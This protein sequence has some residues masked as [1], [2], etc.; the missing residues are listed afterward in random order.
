MTVLDMLLRRL[1]MLV[2][3]TRMVRARY[4]GKVRVLQVSSREGAAQD[5][6]EHLEPAGF[7]SH[8]LAGAEAVV[9][10]LGGNSSRAVVILVND[11]SHRVVL[12]EGESAIYNM[13]HGD[14]VKV[15]K[16]RSIHLK[17]AVKV[18]I[19]SPES[20]FTDAV[21]MKSLAVTNDAVIGG[22]S[23]LNHDHPETGSITGHPR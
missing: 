6:V 23:F 10:N 9:L 16:D 1:R 11:R 12:E 2:D 13:P 18:L 22:K 21:K 3:R 17:S 19:E 7:S 4:E 15:R 5:D 14:F 20:E 8:P